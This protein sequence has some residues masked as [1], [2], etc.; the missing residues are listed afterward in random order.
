MLSLDGTLGKKD[1]QKRK[2]FFMINLVSLLFLCCSTVLMLEQMQEQFMDIILISI[3]LASALFSLQVII[4]KRPL[5]DAII[6]G[7]AYSYSVATFLAD[8]IS[9]SRGP[10]FSWAIIVLVVDFLLVMQV[11]A[12]YSF[13]LMCFT[14]GWLALMTVEESIRFGLLDLPGL[15]PQEGSIGRKEYARKL[16]ECDTL[17][18]PQ[19]D[20]GMMFFVGTACVMVLDF[21]ATRSFSRDVLRGQASMERTINAVQEIASLLAGYDVEKVAELLEEHE[22][23]LPEGMTV[24]LRALEEN[25]RMYKA[26]LPKTCLPFEAEGQ[27]KEERE[28]SGCVQEESVSASSATSIVKAVMRHPLWLSSIKATLLTVNVKDTLHRLEEDISGFSDLFTTLLLKTLQAT[29]VRRGMVDVFVGDRVHC[30]FNTSRRCA[31]HATSALHTASALM[32][33]GCALSSQV[34]I[35]VASG[36]VLRGDMGC[37]V[38]RRFSMVGTLM[39]DVCGM[40]RA[41][42]ILGCDVLCN[43]MCFSDAECEHDLRLIPCKVEVDAGCEHEVVAEL[44]VADSPDV[45]VVD[46]WMYIVGEKKGWDDYNLA[47]RGYLR[48]EATAAEVAAAATAG[49]DTLPPLTV[50]APVRA[51]KG[52]V[53]DV[54]P[55]RCAHD[56]NT[57][58]DS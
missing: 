5:S 19:P 25:L 33:E 14:V 7:V 48:G 6:V 18:C 39:R 30:S 58:I 29:E 4:R 11:P 23:E 36:V 13:G 43:R 26:Y 8:L 34:N 1:I 2:L 35:G 9:R 17:P 16:V 40:E 51:A 21:V 20:E 32:R 27:E 45:A 28:V 37:E 38:M 24:A 3:Y 22:H 57:T 12:G 53:L 41:G 54:R 55:H 15:V 10:S 50:T 42:R 56:N 46:E 31:N 52:G 49:D 44:L 47:V